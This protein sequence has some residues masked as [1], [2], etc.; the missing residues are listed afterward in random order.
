MNISKAEILIV[1][2]KNNNV[3]ARI[4]IGMASLSTMRDKSKILEIKEAK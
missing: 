1:Y 4:K 3:I 2:D